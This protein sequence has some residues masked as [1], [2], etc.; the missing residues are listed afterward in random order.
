MRVPALDIGFDDIHARKIEFFHDAINGGDGDVWNVA[1]TEAL[2]QEV[3]AGSVPSRGPSTLRY[4][5]SANAMT[6]ATNH[7]TTAAT[8]ACRRS[9]AVLKC[10]QRACGA[11]PSMS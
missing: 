7:I 8:M 10:R 2:R 3:D 6:A 11:P 1:C 4:P 5:E 9:S